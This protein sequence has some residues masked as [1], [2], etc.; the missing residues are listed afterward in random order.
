M[1]VFILYKWLIISSR[2]GLVNLIDN[3]GIDNDILITDQ[4]KSKISFQN[5]NEKN[6]PE[7]LLC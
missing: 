6:C 4:F 1:K 2:V 3:I 7:T 5:E